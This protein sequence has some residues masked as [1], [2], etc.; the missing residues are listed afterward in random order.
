MKV[1]KIHKSGGF[2]LLT[3][4]AFF[5]FAGAVFAKSLEENLIKDIRWR[6]I[7]PAN[8]SGRIS[9]IEALDN[10]FTKVFVASASG[11]VW[12]SVNA[13]NSFE[14]ILHY[15]VGYKTAKPLLFEK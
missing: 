8:I 10:D 14:P 11:G 15:P 7:G 4:I 5:L 2:I 9:D 1:L 12:K 3:S 13:G 6:N